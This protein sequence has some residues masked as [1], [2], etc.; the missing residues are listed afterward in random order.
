[1]DWPLR[2]GIFMA[3]FH[4]N[5]QNPTLAPDMK[6]D[7][8]KLIAQLTPG[9]PSSTSFNAIIAANTLAGEVQFYFSAVGSFAGGAS[10][11]ARSSLRSIA[12][13]AARPRGPLKYSWIHG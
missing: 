8:L 13:V 2:C 7:L 6:A 3:P 1:M 9:L 5:G 12:A 4:P 10:C 11:C